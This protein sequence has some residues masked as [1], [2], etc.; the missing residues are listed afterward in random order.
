MSISANSVVTV[1]ARQ[2]FETAN[3][4]LRDAKKPQ[5]MTTRE[6]RQL[7]AARLSIDPD[8]I[9]RAGDLKRGFN[10]AYES[11]FAAYT[12]ELE[13]KLSPEE[14]A[15]EEANF[16]AS[17]QRLNDEARRLGLFDEDDGT[18]RDETK[19][20]GDPDQATPPH[21]TSMSSGDLHTAIMTC[22][23]VAKGKNRRRGDALTTPGDVAAEMRD[24][25]EALGSGRFGDRSVSDAKMLGFPTTAAEALTTWFQKT[26]LDPRG[27]TDFG[28]RCVDVSN[29]MLRVVVDFGDQA[30]YVN[31]DGDPYTEVDQYHMSLLMRLGHRS[32]ALHRLCYVAKTFFPHVHRVEIRAWCACS[33]G[34][35]DGNKSHRAGKAVVKVAAH[36]AGSDKP[37][38]FDERIHLTLYDTKRN[39][40][41][42]TFKRAFKDG[43]TIHH[44]IVC[45]AG[46][47]VM[48][49]CGTCKRRGIRATYCSEACQRR[50]WSQH[51][52]FCRRT[53]SSQDAHHEAMCRAG[54]SLLDDDDDY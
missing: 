26:G 48:K 13:E 37:L 33:W 19:V 51:K 29:Y 42:D 3:A 31:D 21:A 7:V 45:N 10:E 49:L 52:R 35:D 34:K 9:Q 28:G 20:S 11:F 25:T 54:L 36:P 5:H 16:V 4:V 15:R 12:Y 14:E 2:V 43:K 1:S 17:M 47:D 8:D 27:D 53:F 6:I 23:P 22:L 39:T 18:P 24:R 44:C 50:D 40:W 38:D 32:M 30:D 46:H 41:R